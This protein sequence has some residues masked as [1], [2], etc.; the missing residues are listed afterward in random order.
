MVSHSGPCGSQALTYLYGRFPPKTD[1]TAGGRLRPSFRSSWKQ[2]SR[3]PVAATSIGGQPARL[4]V[5][6]DARCG[7]AVSSVSN[8]KAPC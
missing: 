7:Q 4:V 8:S 1:A 3:P 6:W 2:G 5:C